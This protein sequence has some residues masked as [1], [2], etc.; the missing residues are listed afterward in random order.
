MK[1]QA[2]KRLCMDRDTFYLYNCKNG[3]QFLCNGAAAWPVEGIRITEGMIP[4]LFDISEKQQTKVNIHEREYTDERFCVE[5][6]PGEK[7]LEDMGTVWDSGKF[8]KAL[9]GENG[10]LFIDLAQT[11]PGENKEG[12]FVFFERGEEG[13]MPLVACYGDMLA[14]A[15][16]MPTKAR[17]I[18]ETLEKISYIPLNPY[19]DDEEKDG[20]E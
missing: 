13:R 8:Y 19:C 4:A 5:P 9:K 17:A 6:W 10:L 2:I 7:P 20:E 16:V 14:G 15:L 18:M 1:I 12:K 3:Q 11:K